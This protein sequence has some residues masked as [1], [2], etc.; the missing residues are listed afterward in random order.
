MSDSIV[1]L[2]K[3]IER[4]KEEISELKEASEKIIKPYLEIPHKKADLYNHIEE[5]KGLIRTETESKNPDEDLIRDVKAQLKKAEKNLE[6][7]ENQFDKLGEKY[8]KL[9]KTLTK[10]K[11]LSVEAAR[12][13]SKIQKLDMF[14]AHSEVTLF[15]KMSVPDKIADLNKEIFRLEKKIRSHEE[16]DHYAITPIREKL[17]EYQKHLEKADEGNQDPESEAFLLGKRNLVKSLKKILDDEK[18]SPAERIEDYR[19]LIQQVDDSGTFSRARGGSLKNNVGQ[20]VFG[21]KGV[22]FI[23]ESTALCDECL[24]RIN[25]LGMKNK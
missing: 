1:K 10:K 11:T 15:T 2:N 9:S 12:V 4:V 5:L 16:E 21:V 14:G 3:R 22:D 13:E 25:E 23:K 7:L 6:D 8:W 17:E 19:D 18:K 24:S 20:A